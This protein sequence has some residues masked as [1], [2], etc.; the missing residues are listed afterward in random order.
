MNFAGKR[1]ALI[2]C[3]DGGAVEDYFI[4]GLYLSRKGLKKYLKSGKIPQADVEPFSG[5]FWANGPEE[6]LQL[7]TQALDGGRWLEP[8]KVSTT[9]EE[10][11][12]RA[13]GAPELPG[14]SAPS[15]RPGRKS[16]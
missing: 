14:L 12:M 11:R 10:Q 16:K 15:K 9:S 2:F 8:P 1:S 6:A 13:M 7:A 3:R 5:T 4:E